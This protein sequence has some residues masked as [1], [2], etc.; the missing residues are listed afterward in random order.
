MKVFD[1]LLRKMR[2]KKEPV[3]TVRKP[4]RRLIVVVNSPHSAH[5]S[6]YLTKVIS[7][8]RTLMAENES[9]FVLHS[10]VGHLLKRN[11]FVLPVPLGEFFRV[12]KNIFK[13]AN[14]PQTNAA[15]VSLKA[16]YR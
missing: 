2:L 10:Q 3:Q 13:T 6:P 11:K 16:N 4:V 1:L 12:Y 5:L 14:H 9:D 15:T 8:V 7:V